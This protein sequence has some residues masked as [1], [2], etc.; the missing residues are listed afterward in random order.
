MGFCFSFPVEQTTI[1]KGKILVMTKKFTNPGSSGADPVKLLHEACERAG[2]KV[3][4]C[5]KGW[6]AAHFGL[7]QL[8]DILTFTN[9]FK[10]TS[11]LKSHLKMTESYVESRGKNFRNRRFA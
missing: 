10:S 7:C 8:V 2:Q 1:D 3:R 6:Q 5:L 4:L 11:A 9:L